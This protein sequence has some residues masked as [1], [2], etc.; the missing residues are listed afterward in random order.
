M[1]SL[2]RSLPALIAGALAM[3]ALGCACPKV[4]LPSSDST[5][6][7]ITWKVTNKAT[8][9][10]QNFTENGSFQAKLGE[11]YTVKMTATDTGGVHEASLADSV[12]WQCKSGSVA[13]GAGPS[14]GTPD[15]EKHDVWPNGQV[16]SEIVRYRDLDLIFEC[17]PG[18]QFEKATVKLTGTGKNFF[19]G[20]TQGTLTINVVP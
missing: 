14:L 9:A 19:G 10:V 17:Q 8:S 4:D 5:P 11:H 12:G 13:K 1:N 7:S 16:C 18:Y 20:V 15:V 3:S 2:L 6:P